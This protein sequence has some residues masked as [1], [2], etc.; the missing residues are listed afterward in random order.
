MDKGVQHVIITLGKRGAYWCN[1]DGSG[2]VSAP[3]VK[4]V[5][6]TAAGDCFNGAF[7][8]AIAEGMPIHDA[9]SFA[10]QAASISVTLMGAQASM[11]YRSEII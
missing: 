1:K 10:C 5:D 7:A 11:P 8:V 6:T 3:V 9:V 4:P 2:L